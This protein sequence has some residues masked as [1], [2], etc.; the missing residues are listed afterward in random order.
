MGR[1]GEGVLV[2]VGIWEERL[3]YQHI[4]VSR[5]PPARIPAMTRHAED[6][7]S[8]QQHEQGLPQGP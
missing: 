5:Q 7:K 3:T 8:G 4:E 2:S 6:E 1:S